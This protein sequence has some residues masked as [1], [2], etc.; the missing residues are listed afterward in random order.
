MS[1]DANRLRSAIDAG[2]RWL[3]QLDVDPFAW[4]AAGLDGR[5][6]LVEL[7]QAWAAVLPVV[8]ADRASAIRERAAGLARCTADPRWALSDAELRAGLVPWLRA[9]ALFDALGVDTSAL[10]AELS[11]QQVRFEAHLEQRAPAV[12]LEAHWVWLRFGLVHTKPL[13]LPS[14][15]GLLARR[16]SLAELKIAEGYALIHEVDRRFDRGAR[17]WAAL[18]PDTTSWAVATLGALIERYQPRGNVD[19]VASAQAAL[20]MLGAPPD[21]GWVLSRQNADGSWGDAARAAER[22]G[23]NGG[24][25][26]LL[27]GTGAALAAI[28]AQLQPFSEQ[29]A[30]PVASR[31][32]LARASDWLSSFAVDP[33][34]LQARDMPGKKILVEQLDAI[35]ILWLTASDADRPAL[36]DAF[37]RVAACTRDRRYHDMLEVDARR[38]RANA[39]SYLRAA[40]L[41]ERMGVE[42]P[43]YR[44]QIRLIKGRL[45]RHMPERGVH[46]LLVFGLYYRHFG[47]TEP[48]PFDQQPFGL[49]ARRPDALSAD[50]CYIL[51]HEIT[52][53]TLWGEIPFERPFDEPTLAWLRPKL[54][55]LTRDWMGRVN[56]DLVGEFLLCFWLLG[57][58]DDP[59]YRD[60]LAWLVHR[61]N[62]DGSW[63][64]L[65][66][67]RER[68]GDDGRYRVVL[69]NT[70]V[71]VE[72]LAKT[73]RP[74][75]AGFRD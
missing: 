10:A 24:V 71:C 68:Y 30:Y 55:A 65:D 6:H 11:A 46:Q 18:D 64:R 52:V 19:F 58:T 51:T 42:N 73:A 31:R 40:W 50:D 57:W 5:L 27:H 29:D 35:R 8:G 4:R 53:P 60:G 26:V 7:L 34:A 39:T 48:F 23:A 67:I 25:A 38:F 74:F 41:C 2:L 28:A 14:E 72:T 49:L 63:G 62:A 9:V 16:P 21:L 45:D 32:A 13:D 20:A 43:L 37:A 59:I 70:G 44:D 12:R 69:H 33:V 54:I 75:G 22:F 1:D 47:L 15:T 17:W 56:S 66:R 61:Q 3:A 36:F